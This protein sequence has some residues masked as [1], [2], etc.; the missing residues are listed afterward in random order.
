MQSRCLNVTLPQSAKKSCHCVITW[1]R[2]T[3]KHD[4]TY[5]GNPP[6]L[7]FCREI[8]SQLLQT[9]SGVEGQRSSVVG[10]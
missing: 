5:L 10:A 8:S 2:T 1:E 6:V 4:T 9:G 7:S 3:A